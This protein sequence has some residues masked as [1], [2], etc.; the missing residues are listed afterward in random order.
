VAQ[1]KQGDVVAVNYTGRL[2]DGTV[3]DSN[4]GGDPLF[5][6]LGAGQVISGFEEAVAGMSVGETK[7]ATIPSEQAY[8][9]RREDMVFTVDRDRLPPDLHPEIGQELQLRTQDNQAV[10]VLI[11]GLTETDVTIDANHPLAGMDL[12][13]DIELV[14]IE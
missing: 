4:V 1:A 8:G 14:G 3:F 10:P 13:F 6:T 12:I 2:K 9:A 7:T 5:F 11:T